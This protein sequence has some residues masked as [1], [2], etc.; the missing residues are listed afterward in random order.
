MCFKAITVALRESAKSYACHSLELSINYVSWA[1]VCRVL[2][3]MRA[4][5][6]RAD[7][8]KQL[9]MEEGIR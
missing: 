6:G 3:S 9:F 1:A 4:L 8:M 7:Y 5:R 2:P